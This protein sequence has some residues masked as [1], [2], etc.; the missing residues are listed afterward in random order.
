MLDSNENTISQIVGTDRL[1]EQREALSINESHDVGQSHQIKV[2]DQK[3]TSSCAGQEKCLVDISKS[4][5][6]FGKS[7][8]WSKHQQTPH[9]HTGDTETD[10]T[11]PPSKLA[12][13]YLDPAGKQLG[14]KYKSKT[15]AQ[16][17]ASIKTMNR[18]KGA[19]RW[20]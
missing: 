17:K 9:H 19:S 13:N 3:L 2:I 7:A 11:P 20:T 8:E 6:P 1:S 18:R 15:R 14:E 5:K 10:I 12:A 4:V 16:S